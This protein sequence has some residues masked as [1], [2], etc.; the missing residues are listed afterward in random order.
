MHSPT[1]SSYNWMVTKLT[2][3]SQSPQRTCSTFVVTFVIFFV[4]FVTVHL[5]NLFAN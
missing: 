2:T 4:S 1:L 3:D 5:L